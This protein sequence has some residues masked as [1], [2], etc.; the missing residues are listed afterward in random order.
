MCL[1]AGSQPQQANGQRQPFGS[2]MNS[3]RALFP[4]NNRLQGARL[5]HVKEGNR[6]LLCPTGG[7][8]LERAT[9]PLALNRI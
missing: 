3:R 4:P 2:R 6:S 5:L 1:F 8:N 9:W 7:A